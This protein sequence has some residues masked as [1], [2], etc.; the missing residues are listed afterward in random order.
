MTA[1]F[2]PAAARH[3]TDRLAGDVLL[4]QPLSAH[5][6]TMAILLVC[7]LAAAWL[8]IGTYARMETA[9]GTLVPDGPS[10]KIVAPLAGVITELPVREGTM[11]R[12]GDRLAVVTLDRRLEGGDDA[13]GTGIATLD[14]RL[15]LGSQQA[16]VL[17]AKYLAEQAKLQTAATSAAAQRASLEG[18]IALQQDAVRSA[19]ETY[20][21]FAG[22]VDKG[23]VSKI[24][25]ERSRQALIAAERSVEE[26]KQQDLA[27]ESQEKQARLQ[28]SEI[29]QDRTNEDINLASGMQAL[30]QQRAQLQGE[31]SYVVEAPVAGRVTALRTGA[32]NAAVAGAPLMSIVP[33]RTQLKAE[34]YLTSRAIGFVRPGQEV[35]LLYDAFPYERF[36]SA[37]GTVS[38]ISRIIIDPRET[39]LPVKLEEP[40]YKVVV[41]LERQSMEAFG[42]AVPL[43][44]GM[45][46]KANLVIERQS[47]LDWLL[48]PLRAV[49]NRS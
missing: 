3:R 18:E 4:S 12:R 27:L 19:R 31:K 30:K 48:M 34:I 20:E 5:L 28:L 16:R 26:L 45:A 40:V 9:P 6:V 49:R 15:A 38:S 24:E 39:L 37:R 25:F 13:A 42:R 33:D 36:G 43:Q 2:R 23:F 14:A 17:V 22:V 44:P 35:R 47:F 21:R 11:V 29:S 41:S 8:T 1:L 7:G 46:L 32:G 10:A